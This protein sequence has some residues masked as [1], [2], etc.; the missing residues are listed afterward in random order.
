M[1]ERVTTLTE[2][3]GRLVGELRIELARRARDERRMIQASRSAAV[4]DLAAGVAHEVN[5][6]LT[7]VLGFAELLIDDMAADN[8]HRADV[9]TIRDEALR[10]RAIV[11]ALRDFASPRPPSL[12]ETDL[13]TV[14]RQTIDLAR[15]SIERRGIRIDENLAALPEILIDARAVQQ[16][17]L[18]VLANASQAV[19]DNGRIE[20]TVA[21]AGDERVITIADDGV[22]MDAET[23]RLAFEPFFSARPAEHGAEPATGLGLS[24]SAGLIESLSGTISIDSTPGRGTTVV[25]RLPAVDARSA[26]D[27]EG[28]GVVA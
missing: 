7:G 10:A 14:V 24:V 1:L 22:G 27:D 26:V 28:M 8:P 15:Y 25:I 9:E 18:N 21:A 11:R 3:N 17:V 16:A 19:R 2:E 4:G 6:P 13:S 23:A 12:A 5:N 20:V